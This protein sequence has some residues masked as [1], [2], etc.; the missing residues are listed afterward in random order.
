MPAGRPKGITLTRAGALLKEIGESLELTQVQW[1]KALDQRDYIIAQMVL[2]GQ[3]SEDVAASLDVSISLVHKA[4]K[5]NGV[6]L[7][8][9]KGQPPKKNSNAYTIIR[10]LTRGFS[11]VE[12]GIALGVSRQF[13]SQA[14]QSAIEANL[15][16]EVGGRYRLIA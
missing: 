3:A 10:M 16:K 14:V 4:C 11:Q 2:F 9:R 15:M 1:Q 5:A 6:D 12:A 13:V 8:K 7:S